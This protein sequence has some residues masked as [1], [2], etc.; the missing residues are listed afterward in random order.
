MRKNWAGLKRSKRCKSVGN[1][2]V[3]GLSPR[4]LESRC[5]SVIVELP[6]PESANSFSHHVSK[7]AFA[8]F[9]RL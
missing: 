1:S 7:C 9:G 6:S 4:G 5:A 2:N 8:V 3:G